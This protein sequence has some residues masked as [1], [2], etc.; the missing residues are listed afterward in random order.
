MTLLGCM[1]RALPEIVRVL[2]GIYSELG[3]GVKLDPEE[4]VSEW[5]N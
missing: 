1:E 4:V 3:L 2:N 5:T